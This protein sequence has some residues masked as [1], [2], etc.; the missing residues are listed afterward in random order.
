MKL[1]IKV[2]DVN[3]YL[4]FITATFPIHKQNTQSSGRSL[5]QQNSRTSVAKEALTS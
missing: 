1:E 3:D 5:Q 4:S 2:D